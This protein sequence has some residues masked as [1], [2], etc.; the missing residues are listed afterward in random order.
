MPE[1]E[2]AA[3]TRDVRRVL[4][5][6]GLLVCEVANSLTLFNP[7]TLGRIAHHKHVKKKAV[8]SF[9][10]PLALRGAFPGFRLEEVVGVEY[11][12]S[13]DFRSCAGRAAR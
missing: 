12:S 13:A 7:L 2:Y 10:S 11:P 1:A 6:G 9:V 4:R 3:F 8:K 5:P